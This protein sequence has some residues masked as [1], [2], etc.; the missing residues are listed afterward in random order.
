MGG[1]IYGATKTIGS[2]HNGQVNY[3]TEHK[4]FNAETHTYPKARVI[5]EVVRDE[6]DKDLIGVKQPRWT[7]SVKL[8]R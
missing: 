5:R 6:I 1:G 4:F 8:P 7:S 3:S 2:I